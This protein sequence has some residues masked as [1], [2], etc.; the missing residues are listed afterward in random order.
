MH[1]CFE[2]TI[3][4]SRPVLFA[5]HEE[6]Q[7]LARLHQGGCALRLL[8]HGGN[9][10]VGSRTW[11]EITVAGV[12][13]VVLGFEHILYDPP[14]RFAEQM[15]HGPFARF[16]HIHDFEEAG[17]GTLVRDRLDITLPPHY[18]GEWA[19]KTLIAPALEQTFTGRA[20]ALERLANTGVIVPNG[21]QPLGGQP[22]G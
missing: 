13:P 15:V 4:V 22:L 21:G 18:G 11:F 2:N 10:H 1:L 8:R 14:H 20:A 5:F 16:V 3:P 19:M 6:P 7:N 17:C 12:V 9:I